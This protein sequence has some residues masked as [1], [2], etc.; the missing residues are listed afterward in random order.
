MFEPVIQVKHHTELVLF[1]TDFSNVFQQ[2]LYWCL[3]IKSGLKCDTFLLYCLLLARLLRTCVLKQQALEIIMSFPLWCH[4]GQWHITGV[5]TFGQNTLFSGSGWINYCE[6]S[7]LA[8]GM[9]NEDL[10]KTTWSSRLVPF[11]GGDLYNG[12]P[13]NRM[14]WKWQSTAKVHFSRWLSPLWIATRG[15]RCQCRLGS[16]QSDR[17]THLPEMI[18]QPCADNILRKTLQVASFFNFRQTTTLGWSQI[19]LCAMSGSG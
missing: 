13:S 11:V 5:F 6:S 19:W 12:I 8:S 3:R 16:F 14:K 10:T 4:S 17:E 15:C 7:L 2:C 18:S 1:Q 9:K